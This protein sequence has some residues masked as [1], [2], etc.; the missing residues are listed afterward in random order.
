MKPKE[1]ENDSV[2]FSA[3]SLF[4]INLSTLVSPLR[5]VLALVH[6]NIML[7]V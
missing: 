5:T 4:A 3:L 1:I 6:F 7:T 2:S